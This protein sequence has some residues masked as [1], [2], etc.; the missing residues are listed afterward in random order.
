MMGLINNFKI[1]HVLAASVS[2]VLTILL[3]SGAINHTSMGKISDDSQKQM[4]EVLPNL[5]DF[6]DLQLNVIQV[7]Q[8]LTDVSATRAAEGF[9][10]GFDEAKK[11]FDKAN[12]TLDRLISMHAA[13]GEKEMVSEL[14]AYK[15]EMKEYYAIGVEMANAYVKGGPEEGNKM[16]SKLDPY[17]EKLSSKLDVWIGEHKKETDES[18]DDIGNRIDAFKSQSISLFVL[19]FAVVIGAFIM[20]DRVISQITKI[21]VYL[22]RLAELNFTTNL[23]IKGKN[24]IAMIAQN[25][26]KVIIVIKDF[27][28]EAKTSS[29]ENSSISHELSTTA[30]VVGRKVEDVTKIVHEATLKAQGITEEIK[31]SVHDANASR[32]DTIQANENLADATSEIVKLTSNVQE[33]AHV[34]S[35]MAS[36]I[37][38]LSGEAGQVKEVLNVI[39][40]IAD[41]TNLL[42]LNAAI[43]AARA[44]EHGRGF[45]VVADEVR[46]LAERTQKSLV[47]IQSTINVMVQS[48][49]DSSEQMNRNS[50]NIQELADIS[51]SVE[52]K[53]NSTLELMNKAAEANTK[54]VQ[55]FE[56][57]GELVDKIS[58]DITNANEIVASNARS[59]EEISAAADHLSSMTDQLNGKMEQFQV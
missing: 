9:D 49:N 3:I 13:L 38:H 25:L 31:N 37:E 36:R 35:E 52:E 20:I 34:E 41:Q 58:A 11:Y 22:A 32:E 29:T 24:E 16:M 42:A 1:R 51:S 7:Q 40:D 39:S 8:W 23:D 10:D 14:K 5:F 50:Q 15:E 46:K 47:E 19:L 27:I 55:D 53:I 43:E 4:K 17:A 12:V 45:A 54:T 57:T 44:G 18:A 30:T 2:L 28:A 56:T 26:Y 6:L 48:I 59:V 33:A 21:D